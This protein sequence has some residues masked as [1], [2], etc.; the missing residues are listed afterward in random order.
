MIFLK[1]CKFVCE[2]GVLLISFFRLRTIPN[3]AQCIPDVPTVVAL[4]ADEA[5][6]QAQDER[7]RRAI[8]RRRPVVR[9]RTRGTPCV[10]CPAAAAPLIGARAGVVTGVGADPNCTSGDTGIFSIRRNGAILTKTWRIII[11][12]AMCT[13]NYTG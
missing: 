13:I 1:M 8:G 5:C 7:K 4:R 12:T 3:A 10:P 6:I 11:G 9:P 2:L